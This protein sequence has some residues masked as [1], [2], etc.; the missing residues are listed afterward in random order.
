ME[1]LLF[2]LFEQIYPDWIV[3]AV[4]TR[5]SEVI[6]VHPCTEAVTLN[7]DKV[8]FSSGLQRKMNVG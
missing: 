8:D 7:K 5:P 6:W 4:K 1:R 2:V 3:P